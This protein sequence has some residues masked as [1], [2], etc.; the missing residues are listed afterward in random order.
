MQRLTPE[1][2][3]TADNIVNEVVPTLEG[4]QHYFALVKHGGRLILCILGDDNIW[5]PTTFDEMM[6]LN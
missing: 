4:T 3:Q 5:K 6:Q 2:M 1:Q